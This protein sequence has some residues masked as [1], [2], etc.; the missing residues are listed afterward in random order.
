[1]VVV[2]ARK[3]FLVLAAIV[4]L[5]FEVE[6]QVVFALGVI[7]VALSLAVQ[8][9]LGRVLCVRGSSQSKIAFSTSRR[10]V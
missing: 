3:F 9:A 4:L 8:A 1:M 5:P 2:M 10:T 7:V 6:F